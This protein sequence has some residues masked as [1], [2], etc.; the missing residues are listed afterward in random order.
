MD[1]RNST[2]YYPLGIR[3]N[4]PLNIGAGGWQG[5]VGVAN[6]PQREAIFNDT[7]HGLRAA[8]VLLHNYYVKYKLNTIRGI[9]ERWAPSNDPNANNNPNEYANFIARKTGIG[10]D[11][12]F[13]LNATNIKAIMKAMASFEQGLLYAD[14]IPDSD[15]DEGIRLANQQ[16]YIDIAVKSGIGIGGFFLILWLGYV[17]LSKR[18]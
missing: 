11:T 5:E 12:P 2:S 4:N 13:E 17:L 1:F 8:A 16:E 15:Y 6:N 7:Q 10:V 3:S 18:N 14:L 9:I